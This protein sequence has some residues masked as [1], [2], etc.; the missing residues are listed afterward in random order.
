R[1]PRPPRRAQPE[2]TFE[3]HEQ[4][5]WLIGDPAAGRPGAAASDSIR[6]EQR[7]LDTGGSER[8]R[9]RT[10]GQ[11]T[12]DDDD[13]CLDMAAV[14]RMRRDARCGKAI[15]PWRSAVCS[16]RCFGISDY[17]LSVAKV[18]GGS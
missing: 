2:R 4:D 3:V 7:N 16:H 18:L 13:V 12:A 17:P 15:D 8:V 10:P 6:L 5:A 9:R 14:T 1:L 11:A